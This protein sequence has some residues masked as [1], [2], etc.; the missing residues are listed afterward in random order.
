MYG[1]QTSLTVQKTY[2]FNGSTLYPFTILPST[3]VLWLT[4][5]TVQ[6]TVVDINSGEVT[7]GRIGVITTVTET[8][9]LPTAF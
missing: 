9:Q 7:K 5:A 8:R 3:P 1:Y 4:D 6:S 2:P